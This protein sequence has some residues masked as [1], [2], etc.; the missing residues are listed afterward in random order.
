[1]SLAKWGFQTGAA[2]SNIG[3]TKDVYNLEKASL[4]AVPTERLMIPRTLLAL[5]T[6]MLTWVPHDKSQ[7]TVMP[8]SLKQ[9]VSL[10]WVDPR[11]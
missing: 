5:L 2:Y 11:V 6:V 10:S 7:V 3:L 9:S 1:M 8:R 4:L